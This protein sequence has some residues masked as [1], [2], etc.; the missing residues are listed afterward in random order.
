[1]YIYII[2]L[3]KKNGTNG[4]VLSH[5]STDNQRLFIFVPKQWNSMAH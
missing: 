1:M 3:L 2:R 5:N 4:T